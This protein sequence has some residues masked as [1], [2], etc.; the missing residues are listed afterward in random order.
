MKNKNIRNIR[1]LYLLVAGILI[2]CLALFFG[3]VMQMHERPRVAQFP[4]TN[5]TYAFRITD[6]ITGNDLYL[7]EHPVENTAEGVIAHT[8]VNR[9]DVDIYTND[10]RIGHDARIAWVMV[11]QSFGVLAT[12]AILVLVTI[13]LVSFYRSAKHDVVFPA[14]NIVLLTV[15]GLLLM[16]TSLALDTSAYLERCVALDLL[17]G[18]E[19]QPDVHFTIHFTRILF[20]LTLVFMTQV[21]RIGRQLQED[22]ELTI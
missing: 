14:R 4:E 10:D 9:Y 22:Q 15:V 21:F 11:L 5:P 16:A 1:I 13:V 3:D 18:T 6:L 8:H 19:W 20:G 17:H 7:E 12:A 2:L